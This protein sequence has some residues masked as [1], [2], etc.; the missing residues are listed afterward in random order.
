MDINT[1]ITS[2][3]SCIHDSASALLRIGITLPTEKLCYPFHYRGDTMRPSGQNYCRCVQLLALL[4]AACNLGVASSFRA[5]GI[6]ARARGMGG[7]FVA[8]ADDT[9]AG[10]WNPAG[11]GFIHGPLTQAELRLDRIDVEYTPPGGTTQGNIPHT[12]TIPA[13]GTIIPLRQHGFTSFEILGYVPFG[14]QLDWDEDAPYRYNVTADELRVLSFGGATAY[15]ANNRFALGVAAFVNDSKISLSNKVPSAVYAGV[16]GLTDASFDASGSDISPNMHLGAL[17]HANGKFAVGA[18]YRSP[19]ALAIAGDATLQIPDGS[20]ITDQWDLPFE[21]PR[22]ASLGVAWQ[23]SPVLLVAGQA[24]WVDWSSIDQQ[25]IT[26]RQGALPNQQM[27]RDWKDRVQLRVGMEY[28]GYKP[29]LLRAGYSY[30]PT[31]VPATTI[32]PQLLDLNRHI[33]SAGI[34]TSG[35]HWALDASY[36]HFFGQS[37]TTTS[38]IHAFPTNGRYAGN[39]DVLTI[40][41]SYRP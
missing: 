3:L 31:P 13:A 20:I 9:S 26:F 12:I 34:G 2:S 35:R 25:V 4:L 22:N 33:L 21:L 38:S 41:F 18:A 17:W 8:I 11:L 37:R 24:D 36:E 19:I 32:D 1:P 23:A 15:R 40:T 39:V 10:F 7:A 16:P 14:L 30:D 5:N 29:L 27:A 28:S 6:G